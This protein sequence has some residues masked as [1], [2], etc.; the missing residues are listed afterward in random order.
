MKKIIFVDFDDTICLHKGR[1]FSKNYINK[2]SN[3]YKSSLKNDD[4]INFLNEKNRKG[5][6]II[7][8][9]NASSF[10]LSHKIK[11]CINNCPFRFKEYIALS[12]D[13]TKKHFIEAFLKQYKVDK[14]IF[15]DDKPTERHELENNKK[16]KVF[17]P[18]LIST[19]KYSQLR[20]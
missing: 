11:W 16:V 8:L 9:T 2:T 6:D 17:S 1:I 10:M 19:S 12:V 13:C 5:W 20:S 18:Q 3:P 14:A 15:I 4:L 7:L